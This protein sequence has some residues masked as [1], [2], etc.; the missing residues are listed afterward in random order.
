M[1]TFDTKHTAVTQNMLAAPRLKAALIAL[2]AAGILIPMTAKAQDTG[3][4]A[5]AAVAIDPER[6]GVEPTRADVQRQVLDRYVGADLRGVVR[7]DLI[8]ALREVYETNG[9]APVWTD[10]SAEKL[11]KVIIDNSTRGLD[12]APVTLGY[13]DQ[14]VEVRREFDKVEA[15]EADIE[16]TALYIRT[17]WQMNA[18]LGNAEPVSTAGQRPNGELL[19]HSTIVAG[20]G[21]VATGLGMISAAR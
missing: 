18:G 20:N 14:L 13:V 11:R 4:A 16:L 17:A 9:Y 19:T 3:A 1:N 10:D 2:A 8:A 12:L 5:P 15:A 21:D 7:S 6:F